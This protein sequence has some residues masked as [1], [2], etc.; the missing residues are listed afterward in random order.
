MDGCE[1]ALNGLKRIASVVF[2]GTRNPSGPIIKI[3]LSLPFS[4]RRLYGRTLPATL[5]NRVPT[6]RPS[7]CIE[8]EKC[9]ITGLHGRFNIGSA[10]GFQN[11]DFFHF[12]RTRSRGFVQ[13]HLDVPLF[14]L[15]YQYAG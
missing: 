3:N 1:K 11:C 5:Q 13:I 15:N 9:Q 14:R 4:R 6:R 2:F 8:L 7:G 10:E 12:K